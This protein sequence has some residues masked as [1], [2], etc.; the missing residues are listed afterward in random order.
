MAESLLIYKKNFV[1]ELLTKNLLKIEYDNINQL[2]NIDIFSS[3]FQK[4]KN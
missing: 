4:T 3:K 1:N 2:D